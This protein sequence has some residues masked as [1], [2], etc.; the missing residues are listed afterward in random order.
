MRAALLLALT[1]ISGCSKSPATGTEP[2][3]QPSVNVERFGAA[4]N[5]ATQSKPLEEVL[6]NPSGYEGQALTVEGKVRRACS[7]KGC[8][9]ELAKDL[10]PQSQGCRVTFKDYGFFVPTDSAGA[11]A[12]VEGVLKLKQV[13]K[14]RVTHLEQE[15]AV[16]SNKN[17]DGSANEVQLVATGVELV[18]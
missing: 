6:S 4:L 15:G 7:A 5:S 12:K 11:S 2:S 10:N 13:P 18:R 17:P 3:A 8:W 1:L 14:G 9:M 16:F